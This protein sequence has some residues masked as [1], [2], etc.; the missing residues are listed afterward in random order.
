MRVV[1]TNS[2]KWVNEQRF[3]PGTFR[4]QEGY[5]ACSRQV[6]CFDTIIQYIKNQEAH[7]SKKSFRRE[8][9]ELLEEH[10]VDFNGKY[11]FDT[12]D[13]NPVKD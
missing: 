11:L 3:V 10:G 7:H 5:W 8:Y 4:W 1:K 12:F 6:S 9:V 2:S 13:E